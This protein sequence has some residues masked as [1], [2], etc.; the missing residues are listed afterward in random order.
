MSVTLTDEE[1][2]AH[3]LEGPNDLL[4]QMIIKKHPVGGIAVE[5]LWEFDLNKLPGTP[6]PVDR[7]FVVDVLMTQEDPKQ[8]INAWNARL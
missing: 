6:I 2:V 1:I 7:L 3:I 5:R 4:N 8:S